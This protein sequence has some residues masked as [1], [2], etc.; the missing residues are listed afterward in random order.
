MPN[1]DN[2]KF[3]FFASLFKFVN[4]T[5]VAT[6]VLM[7]CVLAVN[8]LVRVKVQHRPVIAQTILLL[9]FIAGLAYWQVDVLAE[10]ITDIFII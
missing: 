8:I 6:L 10:R 4:Y 9:V 7:I 1:D 3:V 2:P 5:F